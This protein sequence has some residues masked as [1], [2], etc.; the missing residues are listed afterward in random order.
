MSLSMSC[1]ERETF[2][3]E[4]HVGVVAIGDGGRG[5][6]AVPVWYAYE[7]G[8]D[9]VFVTD[10]ASRKAKLLEL[11]TRMSLCVQSEA[12]PYKYVSVEG[13]VVS[14][15]DADLEADLRPIARRYLGDELGD[16]YVA[17]VRAE[18]EDRPQVVIRMKPLRWYSVDYSKL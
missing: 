1:T 15:E 3:S 5:P 6:L 17:S 7:R 8:G 14:V 16:N 4:L 18:V 12:L 10:Q 9:V 13:P 2:L 11:E